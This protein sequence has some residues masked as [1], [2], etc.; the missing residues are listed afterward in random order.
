MANAVS[1]HTKKLIFPQS[2]K[3]MD[4]LDKFTEQEIPYRT[5]AKF[6]LTQEMIDDLP[7]SV[8][9][10]F[11]NSRWT[12]RLPIIMENE[13]GEKFLAKTRIRMI[14]LSDGSV[15]I[16]FAPYCDTDNF[17]KF[18]PEQQEMLKQGRVI[19]ADIT[20]DDDTAHQCYVQVDKEL[21]QTMHVPVEI[22]MQ[23]IQILADQYGLDE[24]DK[25][26]IAKGEIA[27][28]Q[29]LSRPISIGI[30]LSEE[31]AIRITP[32]TAQEWVIGKD[33]DK[34]DRITVGTYGCWIRDEYGDMNY[35]L[36]EDFTEEIHQEIKRRGLQNA[37][38]TQLSR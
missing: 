3:E 31:S 15:D 2:H 17:G 25:E 30:D 33:E 28:L 8:M 16:I 1:L 27:T 13:Y 6:G 32:G 11:L 18:T 37:A 4:N 20:K 9:T 38:K 10:N 14:R 12:T 21:N 7:K 5:L 22:I 23:N 35:V 36:E 34:I 24:T 19:I 26:Y 29:E